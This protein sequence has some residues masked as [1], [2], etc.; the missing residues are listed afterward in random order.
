MTLQH[1]ER[2]L[3]L[4]RSSGVEYFKSHDVEIRMGAV[5]SPTSVAHAGPEP[6]PVPRGTSVKQENAGDIPA[7]EI[8]IPH[9]LNQMI[10]VLKM[11]DE[12]LVDQLFPEGSPPE[13]KA[14]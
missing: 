13:Q 10:S 7:K 1:T 14:E 11:N 6:T 4:L 8:K 3:S 9:Q 12:Q 2:L 5:E